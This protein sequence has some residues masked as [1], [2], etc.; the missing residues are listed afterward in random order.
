MFMALLSVGVLQHL[1][2][3]FCSEPHTQEAVITTPLSQRWK[4]SHCLDILLKTYNL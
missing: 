2:S 1:C 4:L 3:L